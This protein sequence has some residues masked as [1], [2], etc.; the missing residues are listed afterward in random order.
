MAM[1]AP[2]TFN[3][4]LPLS[5]EEGVVRQ[6]I[7]YSH[8]SDDQLGVHREVDTFK[9]VSVAGYGVTSKLAVFGVLPIVKRDIEI[10]PVSNSVSGLGD[11]TLFARYQIYQKDGPG[12]TMRLAPF[13]GV[14]LPTGETGRTGDGSTD[15]FGGLVLTAASTD[16]NFD[17]QIKYVANGKANGLQRGNTISLDASFQYRVFPGKITANTEGFTFAVL[18]AN[19]TQSDRN[20]LAGLVDA[21]SGGEIIT[22]SPGL[23][24]ATRR[25]IAEAAIGLPIITNLNGTALAPDYSV[26]ASVRVNF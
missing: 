20:Q 6:Q 14:V 3:T 15:V 23:Q 4:A 7:I 2:I 24:Y 10:G 19:I 17:T 26:R 21:N 9:S 1:A 12:R 25:W 18:E 13:A 16:W 5:E 22:L 11:A 8:A